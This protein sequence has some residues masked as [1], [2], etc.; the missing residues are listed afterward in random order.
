M[1]RRL[2][3]L[4]FSF[5][6]GLASALWGPKIGGYLDLMVLLPG[7]LLIV[8]LVSARLVVPAG[9]YLVSAGI[10][11][12]VLVWVGA[13]VLVSGVLDLQG[14]LR[15]VRA[16]IG[17]LV[18]FPL[19]Y[20]A[21]SRQIFSVGGGLFLLI[22]VLFLNTA[23]I[24]AQVVF[25]PIQEILAPF[26]GFDKTVR[27][28]RAFGLTAGYDSAGYL[29]ALLAACV[30]AA[31]LVFR[32]WKWFAFFLVCAGAVGFTSRTSMLLLSGLIIV[33]IVMSGWRGN[34]LR[35]LF[36][37]MGGFFAAVFYI[38]P[39]I[40][41]G[42]SELAVIAAYDDQDFSADYAQTSLVSIFNLMGV[43]PRELGVWLV[44]SG[45]IV[46]WS[47]IGYVKLLHL[48]G[49]PLLGLMILFYVYLFWVARSSGRKITQLGQSD[50][51]R[52]KWTHVW[53]ILSVMLLLV[54][55]IG[56]FKNLYFFT[57]GYH[58]L[59]IVVA[60]LMIGFYNAQFVRRR[61][62]G[63]ANQNFSCGIV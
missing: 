41:S 31:S 15:S 57:R 52:A 32:S 54:M 27:A 43:L 23:V 16:F 28:A 38:L 55:L 14:V 11:S 4:Q 1:S 6:V 3:I 62:E 33:V 58:E 53:L 63:L 40:I 22:A 39:R 8:L 2:F 36:T 5:F 34:G 29:A 12:L 60:A 56:N 24:Y 10:A 48:G 61:P 45:L 21:A 13:A 46:P 17:L 20:F 9:F 50:G 30:L 19:F 7:L 51:N 42:V 26:W 44:G 47:D 35:L 18:I 25:V 59:F 37:V 49:A